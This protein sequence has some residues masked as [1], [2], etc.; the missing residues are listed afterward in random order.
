MIHVK[1]VI[2]LI[3]KIYIQDTVFL[4]FSNLSFLKHLFKI[5]GDPSS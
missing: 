5:H 4:V 1:F 2:K 3:N